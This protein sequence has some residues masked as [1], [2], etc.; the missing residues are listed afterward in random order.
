M[1][2]ILIGICSLIGGVLSF[3]GALL[4]GAQFFSAIL[5]AIIGYFIAGFGAVFLI[6][7]KHITGERSDERTESNAKGKIG[8][9]LGSEFDLF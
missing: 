4:A 8:P 2:V 5:F 3:L 7:E 6:V 1:A 9:R